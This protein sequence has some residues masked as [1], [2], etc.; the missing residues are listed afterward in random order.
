MWDAV[1]EALWWLVKVAYSLWIPVML[2]PLLVFICYKFSLER[3][4]KVI[5]IVTDGVAVCVFALAFIMIVILLIGVL[6]EIN[7]I[8]M[9]FTFF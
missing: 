5:V 1:L 7:S 4:E 2:S 9:K 6:S 8:L 3:A